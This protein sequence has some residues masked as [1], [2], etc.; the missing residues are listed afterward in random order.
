MIALRIW[1]T[2]AAMGL[3]SMSLDDAYPAI[4][5]HLEPNVG[6]ASAATADPKQP[7]LEMYAL[8]ETL[9]VCWTCL[10]LDSY[11]ATLSHDYSLLRLALI[12]VL[13]PI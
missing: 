13:H 12:P 11:A 9:W 10:H 5:R 8:S 6:H 3:S 4:C 1:R 2:L 7:S